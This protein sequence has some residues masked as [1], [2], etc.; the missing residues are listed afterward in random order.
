MSDI[1]KYNDN[2]KINKIFFFFNHR[3]E[4]SRSKY[5]I[6]VFILVLKT[7]TNAENTIEDIP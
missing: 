7:S 1:H 5:I 2:V 3:K 6:F 4:S